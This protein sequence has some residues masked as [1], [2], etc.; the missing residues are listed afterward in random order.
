SWEE[1]HDCLGIFCDLSKAFD[2]V[3]HETLVRKLHHY[4]IRDGA[5][6]LITSY[7]SGRIQTV[8]VKGNRSSGTL[9]KMG[10]PQGS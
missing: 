5:L 3:E 1:S 2:C 9:L 7:L 10:V 8:D 4:G 6:E